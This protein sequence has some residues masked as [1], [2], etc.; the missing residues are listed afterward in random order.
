MGGKITGALEILGTDWHVTLFFCDAVKLGKLKTSNRESRCTVID[1]QYWEH[2]N[3]T[4]L[5]LES[6][7]INERRNYYK[8]LGYSYD[9]EF[10]PHATVGR[11]NLVDEYRGKIDKS[12]LV[13]NEY[14]RTF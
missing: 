10:I 9:Y 5:I 13:G 7:L 8:D 6:D 12:Y 2:V 11:G 14:V 3:L 1:V 4:V